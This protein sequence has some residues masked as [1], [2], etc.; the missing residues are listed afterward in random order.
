MAIDK[1]EIHQSYHQEKTL[2]CWQ[3]HHGITIP[4]KEEIDWEQIMWAIKRLPRGQNLQDN[5][6]LF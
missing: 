6:S 3:T 5:L 1:N 2:K 4:T